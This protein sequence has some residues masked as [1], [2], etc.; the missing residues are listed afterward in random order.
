M[1]EAACS[2][3]LLCVSYGKSSGAFAF[4]LNFLVTFSFKRKTNSG[5]IEIR[6]IV[7]KK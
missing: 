4:A 6:K 2:D 1:N 5:E 3:C 7:F